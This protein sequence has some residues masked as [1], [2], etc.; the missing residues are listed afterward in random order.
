MTEA[1]VTGATK[2]EPKEDT[3]GRQKGWLWLLAVFTGALF[4]TC[5]LLVVT[6]FMTER[7][8]SEVRVR[9]SRHWF[10]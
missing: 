5:T 8:G 3:E 9:S 1:V 7:S 4:V 6:F 10:R 2:E